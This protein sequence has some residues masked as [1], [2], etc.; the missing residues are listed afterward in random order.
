MLAVPDKAV[1]EILNVL[2]K[3]RAEVDI[4]INRSKHT[5]YRA[6][7]ERVE[8]SAVEEIN[9]LVRT[10]ILGKLV[11]AVCVSTLVEL[12]RAAVTLL[13]NCKVGGNI[14]TGSIGVDIPVRE[15]LDLAVF[16]LIACKK[17]AF[18]SVVVDLLTL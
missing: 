3:F 6:L 14:L 1:V 16:E 18:G 13:K 17:V 7:R 15:P 11:V 12:Y 5:S 10:D 8:V 4:I 2:P 9:S